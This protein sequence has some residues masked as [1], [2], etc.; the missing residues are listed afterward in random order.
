MSRMNNRKPARDIRHRDDE[1]AILS[2]LDEYGTITGEAYRIASGRSR[3]YVRDLMFDMLQR[4]LIVKS[5][6]AYVRRN[7]DI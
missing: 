4:G 5:G 1:A 3:N 2:M 6:H 7:F